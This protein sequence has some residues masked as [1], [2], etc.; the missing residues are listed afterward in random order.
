MGIWAAIA[1]AK[2]GASVVLAERFSAAHARGSSHGDG[3]IYRLAYE[4]DLYVDMMEYSLPLWRE[5]QSHAREPLM[6]RTGGVNIAEAATNGGASQLRAQQQLY[7]RR[8]IAHELL[9]ARELNERFPHFS[10]APHLEALYQ[11]DFGVLFASKAVSSL[12]SS[13]R[14]PWGSQGPLPA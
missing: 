4:Q 11:P 9:S 13:L 3:R 1:G 5:L 8:G 2:R 7:E 6:H 10:L 14:G 12:K